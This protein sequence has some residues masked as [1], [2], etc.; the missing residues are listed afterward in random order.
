MKKFSKNQILILGLMI[1]GLCMIL[2][3]GGGFVF[4]SISQSSIPTIA[5]LQP[6]ATS[7][8]LPHSTLMP[9][10]TNTLPIETGGWQSS[11]GTSQFDNSKTVFLNLLAD[12]PVQGWLTTYTPSLSVR[13]QEHNLDVYI[14]VGMQIN[15]EYGMYQ[16]ATIRIRFD[17][18]TAKSLVA[19][20]STDGQA[21]FFR[22]PGEIIYSML[23]H[24]KLIFGFTP[25]NA[26]PVVTTFNLV[27]LSNVI[28]PLEEA[29]GL[30][31]SPLNPTPFPTLIPI[32]PTL[33]PTPTPTATAYPLGS[34]IVINKWRIQVKKVLTVPSISFYNKTEKASGRFALLF[35]AVTNLDLSPQTFAF[36]LLQIQDADGQKYDQNITASL[37][38]QIQY[39][40]DSGTEINPDATQNVVAVFDIPN[41]SAYYLLVS[42]Y[43]Y[44][45]NGVSLLIDVPK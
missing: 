10:P 41:E 26:S 42:G 11:F 4:S 44:H 23:D 35:M 12:N 1:F 21:L 32:P 7:T 8:N 9:L 27:G 3:I 20:E 14:S 5:V 16:S 25:F 18:E 28:Q 24:D 37:D 17:H 2:V 29:C 33:I 38:A 40:T 19:D 31:A 45:Q 34:S 39:N 22:N 15:V 13:C 36:G 43:M 6:L 30:N